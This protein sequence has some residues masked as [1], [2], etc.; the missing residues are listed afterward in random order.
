[1]SYFVFVQALIPICFV[2][3]SNLSS[4]LFRKIFH[5][6]FECLNVYFFSETAYRFRFRLPIHKQ[7]KDEFSNKKSVLRIL[8]ADDRQIESVTGGF[9]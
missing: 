2:F 8:E 9:F 5:V 4:N 3:G 7:I 1:M 6:F